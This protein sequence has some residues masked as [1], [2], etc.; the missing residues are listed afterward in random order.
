MIM[1]GGDGDGYNNDSDYGNTDNKILMTI[2]DG[3]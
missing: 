2:D 1:I 3:L